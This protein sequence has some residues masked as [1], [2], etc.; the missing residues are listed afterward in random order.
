MVILLGFENLICQQAYCGVLKMGA[1]QNHTAILILIH[2]LGLG[3]PLR[4]KCGF[5][6]RLDLGLAMGKKSLKC[7]TFAPTPA[8]MIHEA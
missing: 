7:S 3:H 2:H 5:T 6:N 1:V 8:Q 4:A